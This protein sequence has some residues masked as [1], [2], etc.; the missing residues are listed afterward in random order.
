MG[1]SGWCLHNQDL[2][3]SDSLLCNS[4]FPHMN[5]A[6]PPSDL[7]QDELMLRYGL[8]CLYQSIFYTISFL[9]GCKN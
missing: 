4:A 9:C 2:L 8:S 5:V 3:H 6:S 1:H 7:H